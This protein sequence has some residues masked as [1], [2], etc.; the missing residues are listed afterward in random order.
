MDIASLFA[1]AAARAP[2]FSQTA[3]SQS[4][5]PSAIPP[6]V[7]IARDFVNEQQMLLRPIPCHCDGG[8][9]M[10]PEVLPGQDFAIGAAYDLLYGFFQKASQKLQFPEAPIAPPGEDSDDDDEDEDDVDD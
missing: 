9:F 1:Q 3:Y 7:L 10:N 8:G 6:E 2:G 4:G 5:V